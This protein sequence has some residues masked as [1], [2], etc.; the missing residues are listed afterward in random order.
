MKLFR[1]GDFKE[2]H[3]GIS[4]VYSIYTIYYIHGSVGS[5]RYAR[6]LVR[7]ISDSV[8]EH[9]NQVILRVVITELDN[10]PCPVKEPLSLSSS[11]I[12]TLR[13]T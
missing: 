13:M 2:I 6:V 9:L 4:R 10:D 8:R 5:Q 7:Y 11:V 1:R 3:A 12:T